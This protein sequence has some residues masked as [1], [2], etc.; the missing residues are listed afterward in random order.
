FDR[1]RSAHW[2]RR[3][4][5]MRALHAFG[6]ESGSIVIGVHIVAWV[7]N[8]GLLQAFTLALGFF[9]FFLPHTM[10]YHCS[11]EVLCQRIVTRT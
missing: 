2:V 3:T 10:L 11:Y 4:A 1:L 9:L 7:P 5:K 8:V 6:Y